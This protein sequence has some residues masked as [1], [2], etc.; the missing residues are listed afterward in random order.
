M[1]R[2]MG[3]IEVHPKG[4]MDESGSDITLNRRIYEASSDIQ[5]YVPL[6]MKEVFNEL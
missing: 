1:K 3:V 6:M 2:G 5:R 4:Y